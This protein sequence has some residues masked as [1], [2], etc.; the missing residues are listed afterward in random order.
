MEDFCQSLAQAPYRH[1][2]RFFSS[3]NLRQ[4]HNKLL[5]ERKGQSKLFARDFLCYKKLSLRKRFYAKLYL[6]VCIYFFY[7]YLQESTS[8][9][10]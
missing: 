7:F 1:Y 6:L 5:P 3:W 8:F 2:Y 4:F 10:I 9:P